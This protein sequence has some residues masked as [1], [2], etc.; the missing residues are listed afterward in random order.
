MKELRF[1]RGKA[2]HD[3]SRSDVAWAWAT[4]G[5]F[6]G[7]REDHIAEEQPDHD[8]QKEKASGS[9]SEDQRPDGS[10]KHEGL[11][12]IEGRDQRHEVIE[13]RRCPRSVDQVE[14]NGVR[15]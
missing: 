5:V 3:R 6:E 4:E 15:A 8:G 10:G 14:E 9:P 2:A 11:P 7:M 1:S 13:K 12:D